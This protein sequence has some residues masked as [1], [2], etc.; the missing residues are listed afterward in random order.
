[1]KQKSAEQTLF[2]F[3]ASKENIPRQI[4]S[5]VSLRETWGTTQRKTLSE[6]VKNKEIISYIK[7]ESKFDINGITGVIERQEDALKIAAIIAGY[8]YT[9]KNHYLSDIGAGLYTMLTQKQGLYDV[10]EIGTR[11]RQGNFEATGARII[12]SLSTLYKAAFG[13]LVNHNG[14]AIDWAGDIIHEAKKHIMPIIDGTAAMPRAYASIYKNE[15]QKDGTFKKIKAV[16]EGEPIRVYRK[17]SGARDALIIDLDYFFFPCRVTNDL[18]TVK[19]GEMYI[20]R[21]AG[22]TCFLQL[23]SLIANKGTGKQSPIEIDTAI[24]ILTAAQAGFEMGYFAPGIVKENNSGRVNISLRRAAI[25]NLYPS[26]VEPKTKYINFKKFSEAVSLTGQYFNRAMEFT[27]IKNE[28]LK[29]KDKNGHP[30]ILIPAED[31]GAEFPPEYP[32][33]VYLKADKLK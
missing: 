29:V 28:L 6:K 11:D 24:K 18:F 33:T 8:K 27:E 32:G 10:R 15:K 16:I 9:V 31:K 19:K 7:P 26:A 30:L 2:D 23:G 20:H 5:I 3:D 13:S 21:V 17:I 14:N 22:Q 25:P 1:M 4:T 12:C